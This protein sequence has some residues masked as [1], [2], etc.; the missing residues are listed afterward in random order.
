MARLGDYT[1]PLAA[2]LGGLLLFGWWRGRQ[3]EAEDRPV[4]KFA[5]GDT[6]RYTEKLGDGVPRPEGRVV[7]ARYRPSTALWEYLVAISPQFT[8]PWPEEAPFGENWL[9]RAGQT[10]LP[11]ARRD[12]P[13]ERALPRARTGPSPDLRTLN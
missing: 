7:E 3:A 11:T 5:V 12:T 10:Y 1:M 13:L 6:V 4:P 2:A 9:E 8:P